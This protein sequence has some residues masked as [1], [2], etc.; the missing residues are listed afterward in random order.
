MKGALAALALAVAL[1][2][3]PAR[4]ADGVSLDGRFIQGGLVHGQAPAGARVILDGQAV[5]VAPDG[6]FLLGFGRDHAPKA[7]LVV[8]L[9]DGRR[10]V[11]AIEVEQRR[12]DVRRLTG[13]AAKFVTPDP[14]DVKR[15]ARDRAAIVAVRG[16]AP[17][18][19]AFD[20]GFAW[21]AIGPVS[22]VFGSQSILNGEP[23]APHNGV[24]VAA[25]VGTPVGAM[26]DG[27]VVLAEPDMFLT[28]QSVL[29]DHGLG[30]SS[31]YIHMS[32]ITVQVGERVRKGQMIGRIGG[33]GRTTGPHLHWGVNLG[34][35]ALDPA[36]LVGPM[37]SGQ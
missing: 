2:V 19:P 8:H 29:I 12:Y 10:V 26:A 17:G 24:D 3:G 35:T 22:G 5:A 27:T 4:A 30:L 21:P 16:Q 34:Q 36:L 28:G 25:P 9:P 37:P 32:A 20:A 7:E 33:T 31:V 6:R 18:T 1:A 23:R 14:E 11:R 15:I 13:L